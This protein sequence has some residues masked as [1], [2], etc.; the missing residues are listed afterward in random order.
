MKITE[1]RIHLADRRSPA[2]ERVAAYASI[3]IDGGFAVRDIRLIEGERGL[4]LAFPSRKLSDHCPE[5][6][7]KTPYQDAYCGRC[8]GRLPEGRKAPRLDAAG[9]ECR[10]TDVAHPINQECRRRIEDALLEAYA[11][12]LERARLADRR[13]S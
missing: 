5:C 9:R 1:I 6:D 13:A 4:F 7:H 3:L 8:G 12:E 11:D 10:Y 2:A